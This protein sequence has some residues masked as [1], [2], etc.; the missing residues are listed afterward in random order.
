MGL[1]STAFT[2]LPEQRKFNEKVPR[3]LE[4]KQT[5]NECY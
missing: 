4:V 1:D 5:R 3:S 2:A